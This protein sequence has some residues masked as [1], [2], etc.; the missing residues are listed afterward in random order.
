MTLLHLI[1]RPQMSKNQTPATVPASGGALTTTA[2]TQRITT[3]MADDLLAA[4]ALSRKKD[5]AVQRSYRIR[6]YELSEPDHEQIQRWARMLNIAAEDVVT[7]LTGSKQL[8]LFPDDT[9]RFQVHNGAIV[10]LAWDFD[11]LP[12][13]DWAWVVGLRIERLDI[14]NLKNGK[15]PTLPSCL[16]NLFCNKCYLIDLDLTTVPRLIKIHCRSNQLNYLDLTP[17]QVLT[18]LDCRGNQLTHIDLTTVPEL[19]KLD[20]RVNQLTHLDLTSVPWLTELDCGFNQLNHLDLTPVPWLK[21]LWCDQHLRLTNAP[22]NL[23]IFPL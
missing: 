6:E 15:I 1:R 3:R 7:G 11:T 10:R 13:T 4:V 23:K 17:L 14:L 12:L 16:R 9:A 22:R 18:E 21:T 19:K 20:C 2:S 8:L 5:L